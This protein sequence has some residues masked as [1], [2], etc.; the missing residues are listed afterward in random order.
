MNKR[1]EKL[2]CQLRLI[3][4]LKDFTGP[5]PAGQFTQKEFFIVRLQGIG[6]LLEEFKREKLSELYDWL[7]ARPSGGLTESD[8]ARF[9]ES[10]SQL[11]GGQ[12]YNTVCAA[13]TGSREL[14]L[15]RLSIVSPLSV[16][17]EER[18]RPGEFREQAADRLVSGAY[19]RMGF[20]KLEKESGAGRPEEKALAQA[21]ER[22]GAFCAVGK[23]PLGADKTLPSPTLSAIEAAAGACF[24]LL[25]RMKR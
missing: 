21:R 15:Q 16:A 10:L 18:K 23:M 6:A 2:N 19:A 22:V 20:D 14:L 13:L 25:A 24:R 8:A 1:G 3:A 12:D 5:V 7:S 9:K 17:A 4:A 11:A